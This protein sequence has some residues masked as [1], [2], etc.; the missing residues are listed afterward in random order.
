MPYQ[1]HSQIHRSESVILCKAPPQPQPHG[2][3]NRANPQES[4]QINAR[5]GFAVIENDQAR[6]AAEKAV[7]VFPNQ[8]GQIA[9]AD[10][11]ELKAEIVCVVDRHQIG[12]GGAV[13][14]HPTS[15][16]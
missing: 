1:Q 16:D 14:V 8:K 6:D 11:E 12:C 10:V 13:R 9:R 2:P 3:Q 5:G 7:Q 4:R 15:P